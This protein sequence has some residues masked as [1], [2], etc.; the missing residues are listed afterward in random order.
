MEVQYVICMET[1][2]MPLLGRTLYEIQQIVQQLG[3][4]RFAAKQIASW[5][6]EKKVNSIDEMTNLSLRYREWLHDKY[7]IGAS[8]PVEAQC[9]VVLYHHEIM[10][11]INICFL[12]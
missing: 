10:P 3:M 11:T 4:P 9:S 7:E 5:I 2:K 1:P 6:Y 12:L 8:R